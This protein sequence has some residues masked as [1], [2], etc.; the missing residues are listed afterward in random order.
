[1]RLTWQASCSSTRP[2]ISL[3]S[4]LLNERGVGYYRRM[5]QTG[6]FTKTAKNVPKDEVAKNAILLIRAG[7][8]DK[9]MA[10]VY[11]LLPLGLL[12]IERINAVIREE[13]QR[14]GGVE[15]LLTSLQNPDVWK[16]TSRWEGDVW[17]KSVINSG[18]ETGFGWTQEE[19]IAALM[20]SHIQSY[21]D[22]PRSLFQIQTKFRNEERAKSGIMRG[23]EFLMKDLYSFHSSEND[24]S[25]F[26]EEC[27]IGYERIF[28][29]VGLG[30]STYRTVAS[31]GAFAKYSHEFQTLCEAGEDIIYVHEGKKIA[32]NKEVCTNEVL[33]D[34]GIA[35]TE[36]TEHKAIEV[37]NIFKLGARFS[38]PLG[39]LFTD[40]KGE[41]KP[42]LMGSYGIGPGRVMGAIVET[43][44]DE[45]GVLWPEEVSPFHYHLILIGSKRTEVRA[46]ADALYAALKARGKRVFYDDREDVQAGEKFADAELLGFPAAIIVSEKTLQEDRYE[47]KERRGGGSRSFR[48]QELIG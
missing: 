44:A 6:L 20:R 46:R 29:R 41:R 16:K 32:V 30:I 7:Y 37:G 34:L 40:E 38:E 26:Y 2:S 3:G 15:L 33:A 22:L 5:R 43:H 10:G 21:K 1:M 48:E 31:G 35:R 18:G 4:L 12:T 36:L 13:M 11:S 9:V 25:R 27:A 45:R 19:E 28:A 23:R 14:I 42:V 39:L 47:V 17:F 8:I 24:L